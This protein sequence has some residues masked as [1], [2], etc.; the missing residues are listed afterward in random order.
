MGAMRGIGRESAY[1]LL[2]CN[3]PLGRPGEPDEVAAICA[4]LASPDASLITGAML[5]AD[6]GAHIVDV[7]TIPLDPRAAR[8]S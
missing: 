2:T 8:Q 4:F 5:M 6:G 1:R 3:V 7:P